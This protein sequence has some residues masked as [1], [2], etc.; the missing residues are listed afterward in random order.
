MD[1]T[2]QVAADTLMGRFFSGIGGQVDFIRGAARSRG[3]KPVIALP[4]TAK[5]GQTSRIVAVLEAGAGVVT[6]RGDVHFVVTEYGVADLWGKNIRE[7][8]TALIDIA[9]PDFRGELLS[10]AKARRYVFPEQVMLARALPLGGGVRGRV[11]AA[12]CS[13]S[14]RCAPRTWRRCRTC[15][16]A[17]PTRARTCA[18]CS[19]RRATPHEEMHDLVDLD[20]TSN[21]ALVV[22]DESGP[23]T[24]IVAMARYDVDPATGLADIAFVVRDDWQKRGLGTLL[25]QRMMEIGHARG[26]GGFTA[27]VLQSNANMLGVFNRSGL[28]VRTSLDAGVYSVEMRFPE[29]EAPEPS[30]ANLPPPVSRRNPI[31]P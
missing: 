7:R 12:S 11:A 1:L 9:H 2:G 6:S 21:F 24:D 14:A 27:T 15:S 18:S 13:R 22:C 20:Y 10:A 23:A 25:M 17:S 5:D 3:G 19:S 29:P 4:S 31:T 8:A 28:D 16:T 30:R 26:L